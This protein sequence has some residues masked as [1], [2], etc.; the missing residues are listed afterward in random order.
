MEIAW[1]PV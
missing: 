1:W